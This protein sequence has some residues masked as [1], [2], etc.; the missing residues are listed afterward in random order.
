MRVMV[1]GVLTAA[2]MIA[3]GSAWAID[4]ASAPA[5]G[6]AAPASSGKQTTSTRLKKRPLP[7]ATTLEGA[8]AADAPS[9][10]I[11]ARQP[12]AAQPSWTGTYLGIG[13]GPG[14]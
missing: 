13:A 12:A 7:L 11:Q 14:N 9:L 5:A 6:K 1:L 10:S 2:A 3:G 8:R 4:T